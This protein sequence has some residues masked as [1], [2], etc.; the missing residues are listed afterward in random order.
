M[1]K[2]VFSGIL[3]GVLPLFAAPA[4]TGETSNPANSCFARGKTVV[5]TLKAS[6]LPAES[7]RPLVL[8][9]YDHMDRRVGEV[10]G[11]I[12]T[13]AKG[14]WA[15]SFSLPSER[16]GFYRVRVDEAGGLTFPEAGSRPANCITY[17]V[18]ADPSSR[19]M[20][21]Q[22]DA[23]FGLHGNA[24]D[25][26]DLAPWL[27]ARQRM[28]GIDPR[29][30]PPSEAAWPR[31]GYL[32]CSRLD[33][34]QPLF[35]CFE[36]AFQKDVLRAKNI[37][38]TVPLVDMEGG[39]EA[40]DRAVRKYAELA[41]ANWPTNMP[42]RVYEIFWEPDLTMASP[43]QLL[44]AARVVHTAIHA[45]DPQAIV[46]APTF[47]N[48]GSYR[49][50]RKCLELGL[51]KYMEALSVHC[52]NAFPPEANSFLANI[53]RTKALLGECLGK[54][55]PLIG[56][57]NGYLAVAT[58]DEEYLQMTGHVRAQLILL[59]EGFWFNCPFYGYD[60]HST[61]KGDYGLTY[62]LEMTPGKTVWGPR[63]VSPR[64]V[65]AALSAASCLLD[66]Y[67]PTC[68]IEW[69]GETVLGYAYQNR[70]G[71]CRL[72][73]WDFGGT[74]EVTIPVGGGP[75][76][77]ADMMGNRRT[78]QANDGQVKLT[79]SAEPVYV[80]G[81]DPAVWGEDA[82]AKLKWSARKFKRADADAPVQ[83]ARVLPSFERGEPG[84]SV[85]LENGVD[86][87]AKGELEVRIRGIPEARQVVRFD[88]AAG[89]TA[90]VRLAMPD[91]TADPFV[92]YEV[93]TTVAPEKAKSARQTVRLNFLPARKM[94]TWDD[95]VLKKAP[96]TK[97][98]NAYT[99]TD[100]NDCSVALGLGWNE[101]WFFLGFTVTDDEF[102][103]T[104]KG[105]MSWQGDAIQIGLAKDPFVK[106][107]PN[108]YADDLNRALTE[109]TLALTPEGPTAWRTKS[110]D[111]KTLPRGKDGRIDGAECPLEIV[112]EK[113]DVGVLT[114]YRVAIPWKYL[115]MNAAKAGDVVWFAAMIN[116]QDADT[117]STELKSCSINIFDLKQAMPK[118]FGAVTLC[119]D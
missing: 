9:V 75:V 112:N 84:V 57:E 65:F 60:H 29:R 99:I 71:D 59:G 77:L 51:G 88:V 5:V 26:A 11:E 38:W 44:R 62:N 17:A 12:V 105:A 56:T 95:L 107:S 90:T 64:P 31:Y 97:G 8:G 72:A 50:L 91:F 104:S 69:L 43:E 47:S 119:V 3:L 4:L 87:R 85:T 10:K 67:R 98:R 73:L 70:S 103:N 24:S 23:F 15:D 22:E 1:R 94:A 115:N 20:L 14:V 39:A 53:R 54:D 86:A 93:E 32:V 113:T 6:G 117:L 37:T 83:I 34:W 63:K 78:A 100:D 7:R 16:Y 30:Q 61:C 76:E 102:S 27:G 81:A 18:L 79:L 13:N 89:H 101:R 118:K 111:D 116:D 49:L 52:Y 68:T 66:G 21:S 58:Q 35:A 110:F 33:P 19:P 96:A 28:G 80:L 74:S 2:F 41:K 55:I 106:P 48:A 25:A 42:R 36:P 40:L 109:M 46:A 45:V 92:S 114:H 108:S 82:Q